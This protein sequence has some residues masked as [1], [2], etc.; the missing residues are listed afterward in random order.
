MSSCPDFPI[1]NTKK[2]YKFFNNNYENLIN[3]NTLPII[4]NCLITRYHD[5][6]CSCINCKNCIDEIKEGKRDV[7][8]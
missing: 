3:S 7:Y 6:G 8:L 5:I 2:I 4:N 1:Q